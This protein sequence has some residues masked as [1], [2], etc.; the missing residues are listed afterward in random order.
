M[1]LN[2]SKL[3]MEMYRSSANKIK[4]DINTGLFTL[5]FI[6]TPKEYYILEQLTT[7]LL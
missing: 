1:L 2:T 6:S 3:D 7:P 5:T 4:I